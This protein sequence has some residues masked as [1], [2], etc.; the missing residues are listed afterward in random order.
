MT[1][2]Y[3]VNMFESE[4]GW[5]SETWDVEFDTLEEAEAYK[6]DVNKDHFKGPAP[7]YYMIA[8]DITK[9]EV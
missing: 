2:K 5:G 4:R 7:D 6:A 9:K 8:R 3:V 1:V